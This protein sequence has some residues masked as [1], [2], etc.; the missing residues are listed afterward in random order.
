M[1][2]KGKKLLAVL[3]ASAM[4]F[5]APAVYT[6]VPHVLAAETSAVSKAEQKQMKKLSNA[7]INSIGYE[8]L[9]EMEAEETKEFDFSKASDRKAIGQFVIF[10]TETDADTTSKRVFG[11][12]TKGLKIQLGDWGMAWPELRAIKIQPAKDGIYEISAKVKWVDDEENKVT[13]IG[14]VTI[15]AEE[16]EGAYFGFVAK[17]LKI[18]KAAK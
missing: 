7:L 9:Y 3:L 4:A 6:N 16:K 14:T 18:T 1:R 12:K 13:Q 8:L 17:N 10:N 5:S 2:K 11:V 15:Q